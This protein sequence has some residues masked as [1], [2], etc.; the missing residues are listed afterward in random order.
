MCNVNRELNH[1][2]A[3]SLSCPYL[4]S[5]LGK[6]DRVFMS[7]E[8]VFMCD[9]YAAV[10][11][12]PSLR[13]PHKSRRRGTGLGNTGVHRHNAGSVHSFLSS[14]VFALFHARL[15]TMY[16]RGT[17]FTCGHDCTPLYVHM[18]SSL[19]RLCT[20]MSKALHPGG[21]RGPGVALIA[22]Q[23]CSH[24]VSWEVKRLSPKCVGTVSKWAGWCMLK[25]WETL[26]IRFALFLTFP[27]VFSFISSN[28]H[29]LRNCA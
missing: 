11:R 5:F 21:L 1:V 23:F 28:L 26:C 6:V 27:S 29:Q 2:H 3:R 12:R 8:K 7:V 22:Q 20:A 18:Y 16:R 17:C 19:L 10:I 15:I 14:C 25:T 4:L 13:L 9:E 24:K